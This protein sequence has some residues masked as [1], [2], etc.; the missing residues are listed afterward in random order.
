MRGELRQKSSLGGSEVG[1]GSLAVQAHEAP[2]L[3]AYLQDRPKLV[4]QV[5]RREDL[6]VAWATDQPTLGG[7]AQAIDRRVGPR[8]ARELYRIVLQEL[9]LEELGCGARQDL[10]AYGAGEE[11]RGRVGGGEERNVR[12]DRLPKP[13]HG[14]DPERS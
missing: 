7:H 11:Q 3:G 6:L 14:F 13:F 10:V 8:Q 4:P 9:A 5:N 2:A 12:G 1:T